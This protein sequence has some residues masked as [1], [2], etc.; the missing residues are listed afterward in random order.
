M[1]GRPKGRPLCFLSDDLPLGAHQ[2]HKAGLRPRFADMIAAE[3][4]RGL[5]PLARRTAPL[6]KPLRKP[7]TIWVEPRVDADIACMDLTDE[8]I[9]RH[10]SFKGLAS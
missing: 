5:G 8:G 10:A 1:W 4:T 9:V 6:A 3:S 7:G 2:G